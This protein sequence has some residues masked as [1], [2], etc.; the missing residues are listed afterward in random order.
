MET[1]YPLVPLGEVLIK[2]D[3]WASILPASRYR[4]VT[5]RMWG[6]GVV[7]RGEVNGLEIA[8][9]R[10][11]VARKDQLILSRIDARNGA[12]G[13]VPN[14]LDGAVVTNDFPTFSLKLDRIL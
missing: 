3:E 9:S 12:I 4:E 13:I 2:S 11:L 14:Y 5:V 7:L 6:K 8:S 10:R 1:S